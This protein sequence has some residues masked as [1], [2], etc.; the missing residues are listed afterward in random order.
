MQNDLLNLL[1][2]KAPVLR[3]SQVELGAHVPSTFG[4]SVLAFVIGPL[5]P[6]SPP[7]PPVRA[8]G[9]KVLDG[10]PL[11]FPGAGC[12]QGPNRCHLWSQH[13]GTRWE[14]RPILD[15]PWGELAAACEP[16][17]SS[18]RSVSAALEPER[19]PKLTPP[20]TGAR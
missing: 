4:A 18:R 19:N 15:S 9:W 8:P 16:E 13:L 17:R 10:C 2:V 12:S 1:M 5:S 7:Q 11:L 6:F 20:P 3:S 14:G